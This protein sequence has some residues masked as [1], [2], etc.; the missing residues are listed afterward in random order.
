LGILFP[1]IVNYTTHSTCAY[2]QYWNWSSRVGNSAE[3]QSRERDPRGLKVQWGLTRDKGQLLRQV[4][5]R[6]LN[7]FTARTDKGGMGESHNRGEQEQ[8]HLPYPLY[9]SAQA[10]R[11]WEKVAMDRFVDQ[12]D[13]E[14]RLVG[15]GKWIG[16]DI[17]DKKV[18][19]SSKSTIARVLH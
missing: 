1:E 13:F 11:D 8:D 3:V 16:F 15:Y 4:L 6:H 17:H 5:T 2:L 9:S 10:S 7:R 19:K 18:V 14:L 12:T